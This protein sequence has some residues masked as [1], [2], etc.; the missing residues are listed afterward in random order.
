[1][2]YDEVE[3]AKNT[4]TLPSRK[5]KSEPKKTL[6]DRE[7]FV[8]NRKNKVDCQLAHYTTKDGEFNQVKFVSDTEKKTVFL[9]RKGMPGTFL[10]REIMSQ[11]GLKGMNG[12]AAMMFSKCFPG[13]V[14]W[15]TEKAEDDEAKWK[16]RAK[17]RRTRGNKRR[18][19]EEDELEV[20]EET[21]QPLKRR[22]FDAGTKISTSINHQ[23]VRIPVSINTQTSMALL[24]RAAKFQL[25]QA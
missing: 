4:S 16:A 18:K 2:R 6:K 21:K 17:A 13:S 5:K 14:S 23:N 8:Q 19:K 10:M 11:F 22:S 9:A 12:S 1:M 24:L 15:V 20:E 25:N 7:R 3:T